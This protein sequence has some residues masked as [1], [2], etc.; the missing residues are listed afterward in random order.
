MK[1]LS[2]IVAVCFLYTLTST[3]SCYTSVSKQKQPSPPELL[4]K[5]ADSPADFD[6]KAK[7]FAWQF[8]QT[9][10]P[11]R[12]NL[13]DVY[14]ALQLQS[15]CNYTFDN[16]IQQKSAAKPPHFELEP[17]ATEIYVDAVNGNDNNQG[18]LASPFRTV[19]QA[20]QAS[21]GKGGATVFLRAGIYYLQD[22]I[23]L[24]SQDSDLSF[25]NYN[26]EAVQIN[27]GKIL[28]TNW[29]PYNV[30]KPVISKTGHASVATNIYVADLTDQNITSIVGLQVNGVRAVRARFP[31]ANPATDIFP[32]GYIPSAASWVPPRTFPPA[33]T[34][35]TDS[36]VRETGIAFQKYTVGQGGPCSVFDPPE[37]YWCSSDCSGG[38]AFTYIVPSG[39]SFANNYWL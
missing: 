8:A 22:T 4:V 18:T 32:A 34:K 17:S 30:A 14:D 9:I 3:V 28:K 37:S 36:P 16:T 10:Q 23:Q 29:Q 21:R 6:C 2:F 15:L 25:S 7:I 27:G 31:N 24:G 38:G 13:K 19:A 11:W 12:S 39:L 5:P 33:V 1:A 35:T 26:D 20:V